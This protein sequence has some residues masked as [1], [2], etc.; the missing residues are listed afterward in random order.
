[1]KKD[2]IEIA[3]KGNKKR[4]FILAILSVLFSYLTL[5]IAVYIR[6]AIDGVICNDKNV[7]PFYIQRILTDKLIQDLAIIAGIIVITYTIIMIINYIRGRI[8]TKLKLNINNN[9]KL[10]LY[11]HILKLEYKSY[12][13]F[14]KTEMLQRVTEDSEVCAKFFEGQFNLILDIMFFS[15]FVVTQSIQLNWIITIYLSATILILILFSI[16]YLKKL[17]KSLEA[18]IKKSKNLLRKT[19]RNINHLKLVRMFNK[20]KEE[21]EEYQRLNNDYTEENINLIKLMLFYEIVSDHIT[22]LKTPII[23]VIGGIYVIHGNMTI[24]SS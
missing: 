14:D 16:W 10:G 3:L 8:T 18:T 1:M 21:I 13:D 19:V 12:R 20:Q 6:Y 7:I 2:V 22:Y 11:Q 5:Q 23:Y 15:I 9:I 24:R 4:I 17:N